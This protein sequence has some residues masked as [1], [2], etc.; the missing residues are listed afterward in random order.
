MRRL[1][2]L[3][4]ITQILFLISI[5]VQFLPDKIARPGERSYAIELI[6]FIEGIQILTAL[7]MP[8]SKD[9]KTWNGVFGVVFG[10]IAI[11][12]LLTA[13]FNMIPE[14]IFKA[15]DIVTEQFVKDRPRLMKDLHYSMI[16]IA[17]GYALALL[18]AIPLGL[19]LGWNQQVGK[20]SEHI[21][22]FF[23]SIP[24]VVFIPYAIALLPTFKSCSVFVIFITSFWPILS[25]TMSGVRNVSSETINSA[26]V[27][28]VSPFAMLFRVL[29]PASLPQ[30]FDGCN[31]G[32]LMSF[33]LLTSAE[34]IGGNSGIGFYIQYYTNFGNFTRIMVGIIF[35]GTVVTLVTNLVKLLEE[36]LLRWKK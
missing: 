13:K 22:N 14:D 36:H 30:V 26:K 33:I 24:P 28:C 18:T 11:W 27:L 5:A 1:K 25:G 12:T 19:F 9:Y 32:L 17:E 34:M 8:E 23:G 16:T 3:L 6:L 21:A 35:L 2:R 31:I 10:F 29:L 7:L 15:P 4:S 20:I